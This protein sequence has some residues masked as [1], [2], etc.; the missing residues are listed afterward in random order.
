[1]LVKNISY[2]VFFRLAAMGLS[3]LMVPLL[4]KLLGVANYGTWA[5]LTSLI[6]W[7][8]LFDLGMGN[9]LKNTVSKSLVTKDL[10]PAQ[11]ELFQVIKITLLSSFILLVGFFTASRFVG[12]FN[13]NWTVAFILFVPLILSFPLRV[14]SFVLQ[15]ARKI[16]LDSG[17]V[18]LNS[19][20]LFVIVFI[21]Y[22]LKIDIDLFYMSIAF[23]ISNFI[24]VFLVWV[25][26][27]KT[28]NLPVLNISRI[29]SARFDLKRINVGLRFFGLQISSLVL[30]SIGVVVVYSYLSSEHAAQF[31][32]VNKVFVFGLGFFTIV[33]G[34]FWPEI[35]THLAENN[36]AKIK[37]LYFRML[38]LSILFSLGAFI[39]AY[40]SP[41]ILQ[42][43]TNSQ[44]VIRA[45]QA[46][47]FAMLVSFQAIAYSG[48]VILN[49][50]ERVNIQL[51][52]S[53]IATVLMV[54]FS[55]FLINHQFG[56]EAIPIAAGGLTFFAMLYCNIHAYLLIKDA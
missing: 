40:F 8:T 1:M 45:E 14:A 13:N 2:A 17:L 16:A 15:G 34:A 39:V 54:P 22:F 18:F 55:V 5:A 32:V 7:I 49:V 25:Q 3:L 51:L 24:S 12:L 10:K 21:L 48:A 36:I 53:L 11:S 56:I 27:T 31:D 35:S 4:L 43:W 29:L 37:I 19:I 44:I 23:T 52:F 46:M 38:G 6:V 9:A 20:L 33:I 42:V 41:Y 26:A 47:F 28:L 30:Y 50:Y